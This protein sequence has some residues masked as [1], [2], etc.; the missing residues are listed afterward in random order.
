MNVNKDYPNFRNPFYWLQ[1]RGALFS[2]A[3]LFWLI[4]RSLKKP[5][6]IAYPCQTF[7]AAQ[8]TSYLLF[9]LPFIGIREW[10]RRFWQRYTPKSF[11]DLK[12]RILVMVISIGFISFLFDQAILYDNMNSFKNHRSHTVVGLGAFHR[13][14]RMRTKP[15]NMF[16]HRVVSVHDARATYWNYST[17]LHWDYINQEIVDN[18]VAKGVMALTGKT[19]PADAWAEL[20]PYQHGE[21]IAIKVNFNNTFRYDDV[22]HT[23]DAFA[24]T[25]NALIQG[26]LSIS[27]PLDKIWITDPSRA[28]PDRFRA[29][30]DY[31]GVQYYCSKNP[32]SGRPNVFVASFVDANSADASPVGNPSSERVRPAQVLVDA[33]HLI[34]IPMLKGHEPSWVTFGLKNHYGSIAFKD[35]ELRDM[36]QYIYPTTADPNSNPLVDINKNPHIRDKT[37]LVLGDALF[38]HPIQNWGI[39]PVR[40]QI[41][42]NDS[43]NMLFFGVDPI[44]TESVML[45]YLNEEIMRL[46][47]SP[48]N[49]DYLHQAANQGLGVHEHW[50]DFNTKT[51][52]TI[53]YVEI[54][55]PESS[56]PDN[57]SHDLE[58][59]NFALNQNYPNPFNNQT[60]IRYTVPQKSK[61]TISIYNSVGVKVCTLVDD[62]ND[63][64]EY[65]TSWNGCDD[66]GL[67]APSGIYFYKI[68]TKHYLTTK[69]MIL[70]R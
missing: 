6:R 7:A 12:I 65:S 19:N 4:F 54:N 17:G 50:N 25:I 66:S 59:L 5:S 49:D 42:D 64:G 31:D 8:V 70:L 44:A 45:D 27:I 22:D 55:L 16:D 46:G 33:H 63:R 43:P 20:I 21:A 1:K 58:P 34:N 36:H 68:T 14:N 24:E 29:Q 35:H 15:M 56:I 47:R 69:K 28:I 61:V 67:A 57:F 39:P 26:L 40:W 32:G 18:M 41:F 52:S 48:R 53:D 37:R 60:T 9:L 38:G 13:M 3:C 23:H 2:L 10:M 62:W 51:Y 30:I 11:R